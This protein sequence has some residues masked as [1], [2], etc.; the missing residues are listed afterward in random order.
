MGH[1]QILHPHAQPFP[2][3]VSGKPPPTRI[4]PQLPAKLRA[5]VML[6]GLHRDRKAREP[7]EKVRTRQMA[8]PLQLRSIFD[9]N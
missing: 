4:H 6:N 8:K 2:M 9:V 7:T 3:L 5:A 1:S